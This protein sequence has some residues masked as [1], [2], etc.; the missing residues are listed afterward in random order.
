MPAVVSIEHCSLLFLPTELNWLVNKTIARWAYASVLT[1]TSRTYSPIDCTIPN[2]YYEAVQLDVVTDGYYLLSSNSSIDLHAY[3]Y[4]DTF[5]PLNP[6]FSPRIEKSGDLGFRLRLLLWGNTTYVLV[7]TPV[8]HNQTGPFS[9]AI[10]GPANI[11][12]RHF[13]KFDYLT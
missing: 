4:Q 8:T 2:H 5:D 6:S 11:T 7:V 10:E 3:I 12:T 9:I 13:S 1:T